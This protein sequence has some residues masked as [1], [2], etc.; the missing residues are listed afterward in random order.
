MDTPRYKTIISVL[1]SSNEG[2]DEYIEMSKRIS[3]FVETDG[4][5]EANGMM[6]ESYVAQYTVLRTY[7]INRRW[8]RK[9]TNRVDAVRQDRLAERRYL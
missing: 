8:K 4:A 1:N 6:E 7:F 9:R 5:S 2:F 3:L